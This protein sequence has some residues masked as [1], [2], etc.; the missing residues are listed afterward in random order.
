MPTPANLDP[1]TDTSTTANYTLGSEVEYNGRLF[2]YVQNSTDAALADGVVCVW[3][4]A[5]VYKVTGA[6]RA[7]A[8]SL[9]PV[10]GVAMCAVATG[11]YGWILRRGMHTN[12]LGSGVNAIGKPQVAGGA[13]DSGNNA[14][15]VTESTFGSALTSLAIAG[16]YTVMVSVR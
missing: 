4:S 6:L 16:R 1:T 3:A 10:A 8:L 7:T 13:T 12:V 15:A 9:N 2:M 5:T 14:T 11:S